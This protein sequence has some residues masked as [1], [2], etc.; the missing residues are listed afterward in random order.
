MQSGNVHWHPSFISLKDA[1]ERRDEARKLLA[2]GVDPGEVR[3]AQKAAKQERAGNSFQSLAYE[4]FG[5]WKTD[6]V[7]SH[8]RKVIARLE[9]DV[10]P[11]FGGVPVSDVT[12]PEVLAYAAQIADKTGFPG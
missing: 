10:F 5:K 7:E 2:N 1:R 11:W 6:K 9:N 3:K 4:W 12:A 8:Y